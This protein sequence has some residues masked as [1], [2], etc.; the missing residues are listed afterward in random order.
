MPEQKK[1]DWNQLMAEALT[2]PGN[3]QG[4]YDRFYTY[5]FA[6]MLLL[7]LQ[8]VRE[9][10]ATY[11][12]WQ[13]LGRQVLSGAKAKEIIVPLT[14]RVPLTP[15]PDKPDEP[16]QQEIVTGFKLVKAVFS[17]ADTTGDEIPPAPPRHDW[18]KEEA[19]AQLGVMEVPFDD[20]DGN[21]QGYSR[22]C[23][24]A[25]NPVAV[26]PE[27][28]LMHELGH[29]VL[30]HTL[31]RSVGEY[32][33]HRGIMEFQAEGTAY[34]CCNELQLL[35]ETT[36]SH[37]RGYIRHWLEDEQPPERAIRQ[38]F[39]AADRILKAGR[40]AVGGTLGNGAAG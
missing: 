30:G 9:P 13:Q 32:A 6:N 20:M 10:V 33:S 3:M 11:K 27:K 26:H 8:G 38:V 16:R 40:L 35:D 17:L 29:I 37:S 23:E 4:V 7:R 34:I 12:R 24:L 1:I 39:G 25:I 14:R 36:A 15:D 18:S 31:P 2:M 22:G 28:T 21:L 5:S 19:F